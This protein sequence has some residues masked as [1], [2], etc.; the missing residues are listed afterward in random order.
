MTPLTKALEDY[1]SLRRALGFKLKEDGRCLGQFI[2]FLEE[3]GSSYITTE[4]AVSWAVKPQNA[5]P[6]H[7]ARRLRMGRL[8][9]EYVSTLDPRTE[10]PPKNLLPHR[11][12]RKPPYIYT[13]GQ[14]MGLIEAARRLPSTVPSATGLRA[15]TYA[16]L[17]GLLS[18]TGMRISE[19]LA[20]KKGG[21]RPDRRRRYREGNQV[22]QVTIGP[23]SSLR[24]ARLAALCTSSEPHLSEG[25]QLSCRR[26]RQAVGLLGSAED[27]RPAVAG[28]R[29]A[30][31]IGQQ[32]PTD[33]RLSSPIRCLYVG[34][35]V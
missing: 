15:Q 7:W 22:R 23:P 6:V 8:F 13:D 27:L 17:F 5:Q 25:V 29:P 20:L 28:D 26:A 1:L 31:P 24:A 35:L 16:T 34:P 10:V 19:V 14:V 3:N 9:A 2:S 4:L 11:H 18:V 21:R 30:R 32:R 33:A 12:K